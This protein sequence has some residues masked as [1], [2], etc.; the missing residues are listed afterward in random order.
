[1]LENTD[2]EILKINKAEEKRQL[3]TI[4]LIASENYVSP[5]VREASS[6]VF[7][8]KYSEGYPDA[9]Y[10]PGNKNV[11]EIEKLAQKR[12]LE[13]FNLD[14]SDWAVNVQPYS[15]S[16]A[17][18]AVYTALLDTRDKALGMALPAGGH[19][20]HGHKVSDSG[21]YFN[22]IQYG[23]TDNG[24]IDYEEVERLAQEHKPKLIVCGTSA[25]SQILDFARFSTI[26]KRIDALLM[27]DM[28][29]IAGLIAG[30]VHPSPFGYCDIVTT[31]THK[32]LRGPRGAMIF[33]KGEELS[34]KIDKAVFP[35]LQGGPHNQT[36]LA[37]AVALKEA[38]TPEFKNYAEQITKN[39]KLLAQELKDK[40]YDIV[41]GGTQN[42]MFL[43]DMTNKGLSGG[44]SE[45]LLE[46]NGITANRN[47]IPNDTRKP[48]DPS[49]IRI[50]TPAVTTRGMK[51]DEMKI[52]A[53]F[54]D[55][56]LKGEDVCKE[57]K[58]LALKF[59]PPGF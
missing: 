2:P 49:G 17:N 32:T 35:G 47:T 48:M 15:G 57:V 39:A 13:L 51:E 33:S 34:K 22:F 5:A 24:V 7:T 26:A 31:T 6:S 1:M 30:G 4:S 53:G 23:I 44:E 16:P 11:D 10:Y 9:R 40:G 14:G 41:S 46:Q 25:Y 56:T 42:H 29:H 59:P 52:I 20:T 55:K 19:L 54:I 8:N 58:E 27:V 18:F 43:V 36:T 3:E 38:S 50:G 12:A 28:A 21:K 45:I 37:L